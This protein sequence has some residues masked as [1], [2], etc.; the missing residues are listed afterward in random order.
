M[1]HFLGI[2][3]MAREEVAALLSAAR[4]CREEVT[5]G[6]RRRP[7]EGRTVAC[8]FFE[9][10]TRTRSSFEIAAKH[11]GAEVL[12]WNVR[13]SSVSK[14]ESFADT[15]RNIEAMGVC[16]LVVR[17]P[18]SG[19]ALLASRKV[20][21]AVVNAGD[22]THEHPTQ[23]LLDALTLQD[24]LGELA[25]KRVAIVGD[26]LHSR[27]ARSNIHCLRLLGAR[28]VL[29]GPP[30]LVPQG[31]ESLGC[32][33]QWDLSRALAGAHAV[34][35]LRI[36]SERLGDG[37]LPSLG[38][39]R[40]HWGLSIARVDRLEKGAVVLHPGPVNRGVELSPEV[41]DGPASV[42]LDQVANGVWVRMA[43]LEA[44]A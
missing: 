5:R 39:Y 31:F 23:A 7:L 42:I 32:E 25:G 16:A 1:R 8:L 15:L 37:L 27:V 17:H 19:A 35:A 11:L 38:D 40:R 2:D 33:V 28:V 21:C 12:G 30:T 36:Q 26:V 20:A 14:G 10:S 41:V 3:G 13:N 44:C 6:V 22:G 29:S 18:S 9:D 4:G 24:S 43:V 34:I